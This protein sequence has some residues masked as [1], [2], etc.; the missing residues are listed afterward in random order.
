MVDTIFAQ[1]GRVKV[2]EILREAERHRLRRKVSRTRR[3][4]RPLEGR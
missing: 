1:L 3:P 4:L 2:E